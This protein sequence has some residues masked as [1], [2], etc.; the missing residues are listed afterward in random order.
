M[1]QCDYIETAENIHYN[2]ML[3]VIY[4]CQHKPNKGNKYKHKVKDI[5]TTITPKP[6]IL[7]LRNYQ[8]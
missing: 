2:N 6:V 3:N 4:R 8:Y 5:K 7:H 1:V